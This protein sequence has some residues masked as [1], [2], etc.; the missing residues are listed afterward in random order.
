[1]KFLGYQTANVRQAQTLTQINEDARNELTD[2]HCP[3]SHVG[4]ASFVPVQA[5]NLDRI[6]G[7]LLSSA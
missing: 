4:P 5:H 2:I 6:T 3:S 7:W 1:M